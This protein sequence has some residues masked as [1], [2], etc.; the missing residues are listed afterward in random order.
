MPF[1]LKCTNCRK[2]LSVPDDAAGK[3]VRC[4]ACQEIIA[5]PA[6]STDAPPLEII[7]AEHVPPPPPKP[8]PWDK[9]ESKQDDDADKFE[10]ESQAAKK[11]KKAEQKPYDLSGDK[12]EEEDEEDRKRRR[13]RQSRDEDEDDY[14]DVRLRTP[15]ASHR[16]GIVLALGIASILVSCVCPLI[17]WIIGGNT[18]NM[19]NSDLT[20]MSI[21][22]MDPSGKFITMAGKTCAI[23][24]ILLGIVT[25]IAVA[26]FN[27]RQNNW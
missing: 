24:G 8:A 9:A 18:C 14:D 13:R 22:R 6:A 15:M 26:I 7:T 5:V 17:A 11:R 10:E 25:A 2:S 16:G 3:K 4:P 1:M 23:I 19:A 20:Q 27:A 12:T 21:G